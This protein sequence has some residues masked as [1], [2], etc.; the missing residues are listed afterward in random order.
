MGHNSYIYCYLGKLVLAQYGVIS[1][2]KFQFYESDGLRRV[3]AV[4]GIYNRWRWAFYFWMLCLMG[5]Y[6]EQHILRS[7][8][9]SA[10]IVQFL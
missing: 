3:R 7:V 4:A 5:L 2:I 10:A 6:T 9:P 8:C 1:L